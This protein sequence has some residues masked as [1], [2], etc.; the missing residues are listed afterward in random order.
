MPRRS[1]YTIVAENVP[2]T[3]VPVSQET[4]ATEVK[5]EQQSSDLVL[6]PRLLG[7]MPTVKKID[8]D[9][10]YTV[11]DLLC[12]F[13][14]A[15]RDSRRFFTRLLQGVY[16]R[17]FDVKNTSRVNETRFYIQ[18]HEQ[19]RLEGFLLAEYSVQRPDLEGQQ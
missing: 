4:P 7:L 1:S 9:N 14:V 10:Y 18:L 11:A 19:E 8:P 3:S 6:P 17:A 2:V 15:G 16:Q 12:I 5:Q 13:D